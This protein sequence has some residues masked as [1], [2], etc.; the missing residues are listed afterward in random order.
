MKKHALKV[1]DSTIKLTTTEQTA[2]YIVAS[3]LG[4]SPKKLLRYWVS[5]SRKAKEINFTQYVRDSL[6]LHIMWSMKGIK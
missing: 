1:E 2:L 6:L 3:Q 4:M 5:E